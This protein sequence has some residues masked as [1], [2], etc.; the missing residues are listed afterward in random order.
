M[1]AMLLLGRKH[2]RHLGTAN[3]I[4]GQICK[5]RSIVARYGCW[6]DFRQRNERDA[7]KFISRPPESGIGSLKLLTRHCTSHDGDQSVSRAVM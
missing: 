1:I 5:S 6:H 3:L 4:S 7:Q 2:R